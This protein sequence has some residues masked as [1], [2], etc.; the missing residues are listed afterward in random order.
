MSRA[1][2]PLLR[3]PEQRWECPSC[4]QVSVTREVG[5][6]MHACPGM[7]GLTVPMV[8]AG[9]KAT[10]RVNDRQDYVGRDE[11]QTDGEGRVVMSVTTVRDDG[12]D[13]TVYAPTAVASIREAMG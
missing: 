2:I 9:T 7:K 5:T 8:P 11:V 13:C 4:G 1:A 12:E 3:P 10:H 6:R